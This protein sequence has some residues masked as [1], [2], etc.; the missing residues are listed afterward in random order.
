MDNSNLYISGLS[1]K[2]KYEKQNDA[3][4]IPKIKKHSGGPKKVS[5]E[6]KNNAFL[7]TFNP[8]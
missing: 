4:S 8:L 7:P 1:W 2:T 6:A 5:I 3:K